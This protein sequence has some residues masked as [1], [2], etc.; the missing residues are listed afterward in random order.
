MS[1]IEKIFEVAKNE[2]EQFL[3]K[4]M[5]LSNIL[6]TIQNKYSNTL[7]KLAIVQVKI[8]KA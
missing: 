2:R 6:D 5:K 4:N 1:Q 3:E 8:L 7:K